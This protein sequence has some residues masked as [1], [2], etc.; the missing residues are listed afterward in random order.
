[1]LGGGGGG[2]GRE[3]AT[4]F[5]VCGNYL[6]LVAKIQFSQLFLPFFC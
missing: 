5:I 3:K 6:I 1:M 4:I 2:G